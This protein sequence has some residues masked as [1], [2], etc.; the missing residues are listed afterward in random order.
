MIQHVT[1][2]C[3]NPSC[4][5][6]FPQPAERLGKNVPCP[7]CGQVITI[8]PERQALEKSAERDRIA[9]TRGDRGCKASACPRNKPL[10]LYNTHGRGYVAYTSS[11][12]ACFARTSRMGRAR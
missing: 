8:R 7:A 12:G 11:A 4:G 3:P 9:A 10:G 1:A 6:A 2:K 5:L